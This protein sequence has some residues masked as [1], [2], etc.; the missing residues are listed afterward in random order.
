VKPTSEDEAK[1]AKVVALKTAEDQDCPVNWSVQLASLAESR[2]KQCFS[3]LFSHFAPRVKS[4]L[5]RLGLTE[6]IAEELMQE[7]MLNVWRK[8]HLYNPKK[9]AAST[10]IFTLARNLSID[11]MR[12]QKYPEYSYDELS[13]HPDVQQPQEHQGDTLVF[14]SQ[15]QTLLQQLPENQAQA[16]YMS[17]YEGRA[18]AEISE[19]LGIPLGSVK[20]RIRLACAKI[21]AAWG[22]A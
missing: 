9:A 11:W 1:V 20:S 8:C 17:F 12:R 16:I 18:H 6:S 21:K 14:N 7:A 15:M 3:E 5:L 13:E 2:D 10:W 4:Y 22:Q 19:R